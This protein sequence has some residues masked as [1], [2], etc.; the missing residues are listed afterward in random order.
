VSAE[1]YEIR[2]WRGYVKAQLYAVAGSDKRIATSRYFKLARTEVPTAEALSA[3]S[4]LRAELEVQGWAISKG[5]HWYQKPPIVLTS[6]TSRPS[7]RVLRRR[8]P[9]T[10]PFGSCAPEET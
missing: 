4:E 5:S 1:I 7:S 3:L 10:T 6:P 9:T 8:G 2:I